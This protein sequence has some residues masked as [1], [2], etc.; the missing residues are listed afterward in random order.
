MRRNS[1]GSFSFSPTDLT[2]FS[3]CRH[4]SL[5]ELLLAEDRAPATPELDP[6]AK[7]LAELGRRHEQ[8]YI[9]SLRQQGK[10]TVEVG[11]PAHDAGQLQKT[12]A[13]ME[14][15]DEIIVQA[16]LRSET[17]AGHW[18]GIADLLRR[19]EKPSGLGDWSYEP[20]DTKLAKTTK[21]E[22]IVQLTLYALW[23]EELQG[24]RPEF[25][26]VVS[27]G[28]TAE[29]PF[30]EERYRVSDSAAYVKRL[31]D[32]FESFIADGR[33]DKASTRAEPVDHCQVCS[34]WRHCDRTWRQEDSL[35]LV[36]NLGRAHRNELERREIRTVASLA[37]LEHELGFRPDFGSSATY[38]AAAHQARLQVASRASGQTAHELLP[39]EAERG[40]TL[41][42][43]PSEFDLFFDLEGNPFFGTGGIE[44]LWGWSDA[45]G[46]YSH[47]WA[48]EKRTERIVFEAFMDLVVTRWQDH[49]QMHV[50][51][52]GHYERSAL[53]RL[54]NTL[55]SKAR[56]FDALL[57]AGVFV[58]LSTITRQGARV[59]A[60][61]Y[62]LKD[63]EGVHGYLRDAD[64]RGVGR[65][66]RAVEHG[67]M[68]GEIQEVPDESFEIV[69]VYN[70]DDV[71]STLALREWL[72][73]QRSLLVSRGE[74]VPR[75]EPGDSQPSEKVERERNAAE[76]AI[77]RL[78]NGLPEDEADWTDEHAAQALLADLIDF[79]R[80][81]D[82]V[83]Y[84]EKFA[85]MEMEPESLAIASKG[86]VGLEFVGVVG[87]EARKPV[88]RYRY[89]SQELDPR[90]KDILHAWVD[91][92]VERIGEVVAWD[93]RAHTLDVQKKVSTADI[94][95]THAFLWSH[96]PKTNITAARIELAHDISERGLDAAG[97]FRA[98]RDILLR[99]AGR[100]LA[101]EPEARR[102][103]GESTLAA[104]LRMTRGLE[105]G[106]LPVQGPPGSGKSYT[107]AHMIIDQ[108]S[109]GKRVGVTA[110][111]NR[112][113]SNLLGKAVEEAADMGIH[114]LPVFQKVS[115]GDDQL[116][117]GVTPVNGYPE[118]ERLLGSG[119]PVVVGGTAWLWSKEEFR[120]SVDLLIIDEAGQLSLAH[121]LSV[122]SACQ[123]VLL[124]G[125]PQ[126]LEQP[127]Q[128]THPPG[129]DVAVLRHM[130][131]DDKT[132]QPGQGLFL[133]RTFRLAPAIAR[134]TSE[135]AYE[136][137]L[138]PAE[139]NERI[140]LI[141][142]SGFDGAGLY[143]L[144][145]EHEGNSLTSAE[146][147]EVVSGVIGRLLQP[148]A[149]FRDSKGESRPLEPKD[150]LVVAP[151]N[152][153][154]D[155]LAEAVPPGVR[156]GTVD[157]FQGQEAPVVIYSMGVSSADLAP[158]GLGFL[159]SI[160]R[161][162]VATSRAQAAAILVA[163]DA[164]FDTI[165][166]TPEEIRL[167]SGHVRFVDAAQD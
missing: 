31:R 6:D 100:G 95:P 167:V 164:L 50:Y 111:S 96:I 33:N 152:R 75:P 126:Q 99:I 52:Y 85:L 64:L 16:P 65:H 79:E 139:G 133:D 106:V 63:L 103:P 83:D 53:A 92:R 11:G 49:P 116:P 138:R 68:L 153:H 26:T 130:L 115:S 30:H 18:R 55:S 120:D 93:V 66:K 12:L 104:A 105:G 165:C 47:R 69:R 127:I 81:E 145:V 56:E 102:L 157:R 57:R 36:A 161:F 162:N 90:S 109:Q 132:I 147:V 114:D 9:D 123:N 86:I 48:L 135:L 117:D 129:A 51:H 125:D 2:I 166:R 8:A 156:V 159:F 155:A 28:R 25:L 4:A 71:A 121:A 45:R 14:R 142:T 54:V 148:N 149:R 35:V 151:Y 74:G 80:R 128:A 131:G 58:D 124:L 140:A 29:E 78:R 82:N 60:E 38:R 59:G 19:V 67:L 110:V 158:R 20:V 24:E 160:E 3:A 134:F 108:L 163:S 143:Y 101:P 119:E 40:L 17:E 42:P 94:H 98:A 146:E 141:A 37:G 41:L 46:G 150:I 91:G 10:R 122:S 136:G 77:E 107:G 7:A 84:W 70:R 13:A 137:R 27:P 32:H 144:P 34:W 73:G 89:P 43:E 72:E 87:G 22:A 61:G 39:V 118:V 76:Q 15:G 62:S 112:V 23:L 44:Y 88:Q 97:R 5:L 1:D 21:A 154:V 113:I